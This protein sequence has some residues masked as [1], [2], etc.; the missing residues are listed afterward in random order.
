MINIPHTPS[1]VNKITL[2]SV[3]L[4]AMSEVLVAILVVLAA[5]LALLVAILVVLFAMLA[6]LDSLTPPKSTVILELSDMVITKLEPSRAALCIFVYVSALNPVNNELK[7]C[8]ISVPE[9]I[10]SVSTLPDKDEE[11][12]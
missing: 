9:L 12:M 11:A 7:S 10:V 4:L 6:V 5:M 8:V 2:L 3:L 1:L